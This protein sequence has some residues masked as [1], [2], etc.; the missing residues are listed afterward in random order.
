MAPKA[1]IP[2][3]EQRKQVERAAAVGLT[4]EQ[5]AKVL[6]IG[7][8]TLKK[9]FAEELASG[10]PKANY[11]VAG[12]LYQSAMKGNVTAQIFWCKTRLGWK[13]ADRLELTGKD[14]A[15]LMVNVNISRKVKNDK[16]N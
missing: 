16:K 1:F 8:T 4:N 14:G 2:T 9:Y 5:V 6:G 15:S 12:A 3:D 10:G 11:N 13:E 7:E